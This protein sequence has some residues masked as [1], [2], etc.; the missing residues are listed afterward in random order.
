[1]S[2]FEENWDGNTDLAAYTFNSSIPNDG[3]RTS[4]NFISESIG[5]SII[6]SPHKEINKQGSNIN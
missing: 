6:A 4:S 5:L 2:N 1:M 3:K